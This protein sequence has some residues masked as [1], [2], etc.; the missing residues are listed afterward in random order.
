MSRL[1]DLQCGVGQAVLGGDE[2]SIVAAIQGDG[3]EPAARLNIYRN[4]YNTSL[5]DALK[6]TFPV[7]CRILDARFFG[8]A[9]S[10]FI[11]TNPPRQ[12]CLFEYGEA[13]PAFL[14]SF[15]PCAQLA[16]IGDVARLEWLINSALHS[17]AVP[18]IDS[19]DLAHLDSADYP[20]LIL[21]L[22]PSLRFIESRWP[23]DRIWHENK[24]GAE[25]DGAVNLGAGGCRLEIR[26]LGDDVVFRS[27]ESGEFALRSALLKGHT[28]DTAVAAALA[29]DPLFDTAHG[30]RRLF[31]EG[32]VTGFTLAPNPGADR[33]DPAKQP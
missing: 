21:A 23:I 30:L 19:R 12:V 16:Y 22:Q 15:P 4:H 26:Q 29:S 3:L 31:A 10:E 6:A 1:R 28:L 17:P 32:L 27:L 5:A 7:V 14:E 18:P 8:Y 11:K 20:R 2:E 9:A 24:P 13:L 25:G 33:L